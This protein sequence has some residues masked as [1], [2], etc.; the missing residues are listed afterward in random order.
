MKAGCTWAGNVARHREMTVSQSVLSWQPEQPACKGIQGASSS[1]SPL[2]GKE[3]Q[4]HGAPRAPGMLVYRQL[5][6]EGQPRACILWCSS[7]W[8]MGYAIQPWIDS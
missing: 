1:P 8:D 7:W 4:Y 3:C 5:R 6:G 2:V